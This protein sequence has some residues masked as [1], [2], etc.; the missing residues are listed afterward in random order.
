MKINK[1]LLFGM[2]MLSSISINDESFA[3]T[4]NYVDNPELITFGGSNNDIFYSIIETSDRGYVAAGYSAS[5]NAGFNNNGNEDAIIVKYDS[6]GTQQWIKNFGGSNSDFFRSVIETSDGGFVCTGY[7]RSTNAGFSNKGDY[8]AI[9]VKYNPNG[10]QQWVKNFG[11]SSD[12][13]KFYSVIETLDGGF[14]CAGESNSADAGFTHKRLRDAIIVKYNSSGTQEW[15]KNFGGA[16]YDSFKSVSLTSDGGFVCVGESSSSDAISTSVGDYE[17]I[18]VKYNINGEQQ[19]VKSFG[20][21]NYEYF[22]S[23]IET[24]DGGFICAGNSNST[25]AGFNSK[26]ARDA[27]IVKYNS[28]GTQEWVSNFGGSSGDKFYSAIEILDGGFVCVGESASSDAGFSNNGVFDAIIAKYNTNGEQ[29]W[30]KSFGGSTFDYF[31]SVIETSHGELMATGYSSSLNAGFEHK[32]LDDA[33]ITIYAIEDECLSSIKLAENNPT[34]ENISNAR[35]LINAMPEGELKEQYQA[36]LNAII[37]EITFDKKNHSANLDIYIKCENMISLSL[38]TSSIT[39]D[40]FNGTEDLIKENA[41]NLTVNSSLP[42]K[43]DAYLATE[44]QNASKNKTMDKEILNLKANGSD[45]YKSFED[46]NITPITLVDNQE[47]GRD[48]VHG[49][50]IMLKGGIPHEKDVYKTTIKFEATQK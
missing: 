20:G 6:N 25:D 11:G 39:F 31:T 3:S 18:I 9:M 29:E 7:S 12:E 41:V 48:K 38:D 16:S 13:D 17:A 47:A 24:S 35:M 1:I 26:G 40:D 5:T 19:W 45:E 30:V 42:Y 22:E 2:V 4:I 27:I 15:V 43:V 14:I 36:R 28:S 46:V 37:P 32:G 33:I 50:D 49:I 21:S 23:V 10:E 34:H 8:D 44:I